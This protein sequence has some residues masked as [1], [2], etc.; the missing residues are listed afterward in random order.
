MASTKSIVS[1]ILLCFLLTA[2]G[3]GGRGGGIMVAEA[4]VCLSQSHRFVG[5]CIRGSN[6]ANVCKTEG[7]PGGECKGFRRR[8]FCA[9]NC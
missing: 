3:M 4:R 5:S 9:K 6:C 8:C 2:T 1:A 7:F